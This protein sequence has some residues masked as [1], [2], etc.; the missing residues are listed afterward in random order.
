MPNFNIASESRVSI[1]HEGW[2]TDAKLALHQGL[3]KL[4]G[5]TS[6]LTVGG[7]TG[8]YVVFDPTETTGAEVEEA[9][10]QLANEALP[11]HGFNPR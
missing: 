9:A 4:K 10:A 8:C 5:V 6:V 3:A 1:D 2:P 7:N 11:G